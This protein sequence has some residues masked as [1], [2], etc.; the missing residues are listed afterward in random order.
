METSSSATKSQMRSLTLPI[1]ADAGEGE[2]QHGEEFAAVVANRGGGVGFGGHVPGG[3]DGEEPD[4][5]GEDGDVVGAEVEGG[6]ERRWG[7]VVF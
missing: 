3:E 5:A 7:G 2:E 1:M 6:R 4:D